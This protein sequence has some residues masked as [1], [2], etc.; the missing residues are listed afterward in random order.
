MLRTEF[1]L[2][3][4]KLVR[5][6]SDPMSELQALPPHADPVSCARPGF[7]PL[8][9]VVYSNAYRHELSLQRV[10]SFYSSKVS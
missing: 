7:S 3:Q 10:V 1:D 4:I 5:R 6:M 8:G 9:V 2:S